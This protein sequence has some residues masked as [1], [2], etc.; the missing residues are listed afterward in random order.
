MLHTHKWPCSVLWPRRS[1][2]TRPAHPLLQRKDPSQRATAEELLSHEWLSGGA[3]T[4]LVL[5]FEV[6][7]QMMSYTV[8]SKL[9]KAA[10]KVSSGLVGA[11]GRCVS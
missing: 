10:I 2:R 5:R 9:H 11:G 7:E 6:L 8:R 3:N 4:Q 1:N